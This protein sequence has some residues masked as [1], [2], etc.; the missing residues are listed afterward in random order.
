MT[1]VF[2]KVSEFSQKFPLSK[3]TMALLPLKNTVA[4]FGLP[5]YKNITSSL[6]VPFFLSHC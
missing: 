4:S 2:V 3:I 6:S 1:I 5:W